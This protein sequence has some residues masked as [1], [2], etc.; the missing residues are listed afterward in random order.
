MFEIY[1]DAD[2]IYL[3]EDRLAK[4]L[5]WSVLRHHATQCFILPSFPGRMIVVSLAP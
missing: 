1:G 3:L 5:P 2:T 4:M